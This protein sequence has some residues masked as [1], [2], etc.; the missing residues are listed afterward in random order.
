[1]EEKYGFGIAK[2]GVGPDAD[3]NRA[4]WGREEFFDI[5]TRQVPLKP[6][7]E[8]N[9]QK[10]EYLCSF[11]GIKLHLLTVNHHLAHYSITVTLLNTTTCCELKVV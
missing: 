11:G 2:F 5:D 8:K 6:L 1:M 4:E 10:E 7:K 9:T 3:K